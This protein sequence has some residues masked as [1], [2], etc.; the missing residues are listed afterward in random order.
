[1]I[2][3]VEMHDG[4]WRPS[5]W[6]YRLM[7]LE[8][9]SCLVHHKRGFLYM[10]APQN[11][12]FWTDNPMNT[13]MIWGYPHFENLQF[14]LVVWNILIFAY[15]ETTNQNYWL[16]FCQFLAEFVF[17]IFSSVS[18]MPYPRFSAIH[19]AVCLVVCCFYMLGFHPNNNQRHL[20]IQ[21]IWWY[22]TDPNFP[23]IKHGPENSE[24][25]APPCQPQGFSS[26]FSLYLHGP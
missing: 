26:S 18:I 10:G 13:I 25:G 17:L 7:V 9:N 14:W 22:L 15:I 16:R 23:K 12:W 11:R 1:M 3:H 6:L 19:S 20:W 5:H 24:N 21:K 4:C 2:S 8:T